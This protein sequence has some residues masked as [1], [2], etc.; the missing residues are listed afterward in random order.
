[1]RIN[2]RKLFLYILIIYLF[3]LF[4]NTNINGNNVN[5]L[6]LL[7][8]SRREYLTFIPLS[9][10]EKFYPILLIDD[11]IKNYLVNKVQELYYGKTLIS[12]DT[13]IYNFSINL[14]A[15]FWRRCENIFLVSDDEEALYLSLL[16]SKYKAPL[17]W[18]REEEQFKLILKNVIRNLSVRR[19]FFFESHKIFFSF[20][21]NVSKNVIKDYGEAL[22]L[23]NE[24]KNTSLLVI[25]HKNDTYNIIAIE[26]AVA[27]NAYLKILGSL[28]ELDK[29]L[30]VLY[31]KYTIYIASF[32][33]LKG[34][35][36]RGNNINLLYSYFIKKYDGR[37]IGS[38]IGI[39]SGA[40]LKIASLFATRN[41]LYKFKRVRKMALI[42]MMD[43]ENLAQKIGRIIKR[44]GGIALLYD[45]EKEGNILDVFKD[46]GELVFINLHGAPW[47]MAP[48][49]TGPLL[50]TPYNIPTI[51]PTII[52]TLS[53]E[54]A[55]FE[56]LTSP[57]QSIVLS[58]LFKGAIAYIGAMSLEYTSGLELST[59]HP[60]LV[61]SMIL[62]GESLG[63]IVR[64]L[65]N[66]H[67]RE[68]NKE[69]PEY[70]AYTVLF[71]D[72]ELHLTLSQLKDK[73]IVNREDNT[74]KILFTN[75]S[76]LA[77]GRIVINTSFEKIKGFDLREPNT[78]I[79][80]YAEEIQKDRTQI[81]FFI[82]RPF[83]SVIGDYK[84][85]D[86][87]KMKIMFKRNIELIIV[88]LIIIVIIVTILLLKKWSRIK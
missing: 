49:S 83:S 82:T 12:H 10:K 66:I 16:A 76:S 65:N 6:I 40:N 37:N 18:F 80:W 61:I 71:G 38:R 22:N 32:K 48:T 11:E 77:Y 31:P 39:I 2:N 79:W 42:Y 13:D 27:K 81:F 3:T 4:L 63:E 64:V 30:D 53:C 44:S 50:L 26:Y 72:P 68:R 73:Y 51:P 86:T 33:Y 1:M 57:F 20:L 67:I 8:R 60:E 43:S 59:A 85:G 69:A 17:I 54:T 29:I 34:N 41:L 78:N 47:G 23:Y 45:V 74:I 70:A 5:D 58:F 21:N 7:A 25:T 36:S 56:K 28:K 55:S 62:N 9:I 19:I 84:P 24:D 75:V 87:V 35:L 46:P 15:N 14:A 52:V 88:I